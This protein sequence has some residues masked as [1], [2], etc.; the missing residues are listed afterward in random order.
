[1]IYKKRLII[2]G[3]LLF[4]IAVV[5][6]ACGGKKQGS[7]NVY[8]G[9]Q[10]TEKGDTILVNGESNLLPGSRIHGAVI[11]D[12]S[13]ALS[14]TTEVVDKK[15]NFKMELEHHKYGD[16]EVIVVFEFLEGFQ[17][18]EIVEHYGEGGELLEGPYVY[19]DDHWDVDQINKKAEVR[20]KIDAD[21]DNKKHV[22]AE[23]EW[24]ERPDDYGE[25]R[26]WFEVDDITDDSEYFYLHGKTNLLEGS[27]ISGYY[28]EGRRSDKT[29]INPDGSF[30]LK[31]EYKYSEDPYFVLEFSPSSQWESIR[32]NYGYDG[33]KLVGNNVETSGSSMSIKETIEY[34]HD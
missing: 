31:I 20:L 4:L 13:D 27:V 18:E 33:E 11:V 5:F 7:L 15:G 3:A 6:T 34:E 2:R 8:L 12:E 19:V 21:D 16:A 10:V 1:M 14:T 26:V 25:P 9:G 32:E 30:D 23:P 24:G 22:F 29:R 28:S 17:D